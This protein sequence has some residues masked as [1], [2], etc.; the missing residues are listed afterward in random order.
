ML[1]LS[2]DGPPMEFDEAE[3]TPREMGAVEVDGTGG[4]TLVEAVGVLCSLRM[5]SGEGWGG[6]RR[7]G[8]RGSA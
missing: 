6:S 5:R 3:A 8:G 4:R 7:R 1:L 2:P